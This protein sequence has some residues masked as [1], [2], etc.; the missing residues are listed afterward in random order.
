VPSSRDPKL[1]ELNYSASGSMRL[2]VARGGDVTISLAEGERVQS[3]SAGTPSQYKIMTG[4]P[5]DGFLIHAEPG[6]VASTLSVL[7]DR[8]TYNFV[9]TP[10]PLTRAPYLIQ[11]T[12]LAAPAGAATARP[13]AEE[14][15]GRG[16]YRLTGNKELRPVGMTDD[17]AKTYIEWSPEQALPAVFAIDRLGREEMVNGYMR[18]DIFTLD[19]VYARL[20][21]RIDRSEAGAR[22]IERRSRK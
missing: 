22:R 13:S 12:Y 5:A 7:T 18:D 21:F 4:D 10:V 11:L 8:R 9:L 3:I 16:K 20:V 19:R 15:S 14:V 1:L 2:L 6:A 17:G